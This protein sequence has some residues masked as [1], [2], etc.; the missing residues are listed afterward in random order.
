MSDSIRDAAIKAWSKALDADDEHEHEPIEAA[1]R[2]QVRAAELRKER[3]I[4]EWALD[5][6][7]I[8][9]EGMGCHG[10]GSVATELIGARLDALD[11]DKGN[12]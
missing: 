5:Q 1:I 7:P 10:E 3:E 2:E 9:E 6:I 8:C 11:P 4:L 12:P